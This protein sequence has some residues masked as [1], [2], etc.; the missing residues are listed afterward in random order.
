[1][2]GATASCGTAAHLVL[3]GSAN[4]GG[5]SVRR[6][7]AALARAVLVAHREAPASRLSMT[8]P[9]VP[10][11]WP[12]GVARMSNG[13]YERQNRQAFGTSFLTAGHIAVDTSWTRRIASRII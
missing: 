10:F 1:Q 13:I 3:S 6:L 7:Y 5:S 8:L 9:L 12:S 2:G 11:G 4:C